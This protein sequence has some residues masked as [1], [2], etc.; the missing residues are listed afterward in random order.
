MPRDVTVQTTAGG[1]GMGEMMGMV[2]AENGWKLELFAMPYAAGSSHS[3]AVY[4][5]DWTAT[6]GNQRLGPTFV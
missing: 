1:F 5:G 3:D 2:K 4:G 6:A